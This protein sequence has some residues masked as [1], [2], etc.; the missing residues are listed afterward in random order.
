[1]LLLFI[2]ILYCLF[3]IGLFN[4][5]VKIH[6]IFINICLNHMIVGIS[7]KSQGPVIESKRTGAGPR[8]GG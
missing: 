1:M 7:T 8:P 3:R 2:P 4:F 5:G 6:C